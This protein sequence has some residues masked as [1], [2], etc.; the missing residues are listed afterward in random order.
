MHDCEF[1][2]GEMQQQ[3]VLSRFRFEG[4]TIYVEDVP[5]WVCNRC[6]AHNRVVYEDVEL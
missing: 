3:H 1:C 2:E 6:I 5:V 4:E